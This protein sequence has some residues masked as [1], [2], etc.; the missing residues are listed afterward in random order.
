MLVNLKKLKLFQCGSRQKHALL[1]EVNEGV[2]ISLR[3]K[4]NVDVRNVAEKFGGGGHVKA[5][6]AMQKGVGLEEARKNLL[7]ALKDEM[8][9]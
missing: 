6:G 5:S 4:N 7:K 2:K 3:S 8:Q 1:K 9:I